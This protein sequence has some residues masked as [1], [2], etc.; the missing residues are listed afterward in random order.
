MLIKKLNRYFI[1]NFDPHKLSFSTTLSI[2]K[3]KGFKL[4]QICSQVV[5][6]LQAWLV[7]LSAITKKQ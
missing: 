5:N 1:K 4:I 3:M 6:T 7:N 2:R